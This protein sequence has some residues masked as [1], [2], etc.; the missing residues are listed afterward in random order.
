[1]KQSVAF[2][3]GTTT[4]CTRNST[5]SVNTLFASTVAPTLW[6]LVLYP[7]VGICLRDGGRKMME[8]E[9]VPHLIHDQL[10]VDYSSRQ[11]AHSPAAV[12]TL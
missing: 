6:P 1:M 11:L 8:R 5:K 4:S 2:L 10:F 9:N 3:C 7:F 12:G